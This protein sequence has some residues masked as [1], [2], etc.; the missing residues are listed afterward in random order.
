MSKKIMIKYVKNKNKFHLNEGFIFG[1]NVEC[2][3]IT[4]F[5]IN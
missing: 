2:K 3:I 5:S 1:R 4:T